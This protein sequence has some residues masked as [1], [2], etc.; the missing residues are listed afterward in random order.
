MFEGLC[1]LGRSIII[2]FVRAFLVHAPMER[3][4]FGWVG[5]APSMC[6]A[7]CPRP[8][9]Q[10]L[11]MS[12]ALVDSEGKCPMCEQ[13]V[14]ASSIVKVENPEEYLNRLSKQNDNEGD[15]QK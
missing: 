14:Q 7:P 12:Q 2:M 3:L 6:L 13:D 11:V 9:T 1:L 4:S 15:K 8:R 10:M 5:W